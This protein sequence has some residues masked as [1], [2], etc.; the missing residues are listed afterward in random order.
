MRKVL[1]LIVGLLGLRQPGLHH[2]VEQLA[3]LHTRPAMLAEEPHGVPLLV[4]GPAELLS[5]LH[6]RLSKTEAPGVSARV[7]QARPRFLR[8]TLSVAAASMPR[9]NR[10]FTAQA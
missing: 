7:M 6:D 10:T 1:A 3:E 8:P 5:P 4:G 9:R 2:L